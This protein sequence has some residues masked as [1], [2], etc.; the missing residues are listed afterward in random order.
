MGYW[1]LYP[2]EATAR[3]LAVVHSELGR[4]PEEYEGE[5]VKEPPSGG[6]SELPLSVEGR[7]TLF[8]SLAADSG[9]D[10]GLLDFG[11]MPLLGWDGKEITLTGL[12]GAAAEYTEDFRQNVAQRRCQGPEDRE[13]VE[14]LFCLVGEDD[15]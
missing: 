6:D 12:D 15:G 5:V 4:A 10:G 1:T 7:T 3:N 11:E 2:G 13:G 9:G 14:G 8:E